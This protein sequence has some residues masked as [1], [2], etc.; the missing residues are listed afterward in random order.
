VASEAEPHASPEAGNPFAAAVAATPRGRR[1]RLPEY[2]RRSAQYRAQAEDLGRLSHKI[3]NFRG[4]S[5]AV[6]FIALLVTAFGESRLVPALIAV[7]GGAAFAVLVVWHARVFAAQDLAWRWWRV[8]QSAEARCR[9]TWR[10]LKDDGAEFIKP[11]HPYTADLDVFGQGS[12]FQL[13][14]V[15]HT[16]HGRRALAG[17]LS[18]AAPD[19]ELRQRQDAVRVLGPELELRQELE[20][21]SLGTAD[22]PHERPSKGSSARDLEA[23]LAWAESEPRLSKDPLLVWGSRIFPPITL[24]SMVATGVFDLSSFVWGVPLIVQ[25]FL[26]AR[27]ASEAGRVF[28]IVSATQGAFTRFK[29]TFK[30]L[31]DTSFDSPLLATLRNMLRGSSEPA[32]A[33]M[34]RF[35]RALSWFELRHNGM[36]YPFVTL[37]LLW[38]IHSVLALERW[39]AQTGRSL[40]AWFEA[41]GQ[42]E[43]L[44]SLAGLGYDNP[45][46]SLPEVVNSPVEFSA[47]DL[48]HPLLPPEAR[49][50]NNVYLPGPGHAL[51]VTGS[52]MS[53]KSTLL[54]AMGLAVV[55]ALAGAPVC[56]AR[57][58]VGRSNVYTSMRISDSL[59]GGVSHFYA[60][61]KKLRAAV[62]ATHEPLPLF[63]L[64][65]E[66]LHGT[67]SEER[68][69]GARWVLAE[70]LRAGAIGA[71]STHDLGLCQLPPALMQSVQ[72]VHFRESVLNGKM[73]F[74]YKLRLGPVTG[75][76]AL[77]LMRSL[78][79][80][81]PLPE[82]SA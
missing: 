17:F 33:Q 23:L 59:A 1:T 4:L 61:L 29:P 62:E 38:D 30:R 69:L 75:G 13:M 32:S 79:L 22:P 50:G 81:V 14:S 60:E 58:R 73:V 43:A 10:E 6:A 56:A 76:N 26:T 34:R 41:L 28:N 42:W 9:E 25:L 20:A 15:A 70:L 8:N 19:V 82:A 67:N 5:F 12:L 49:V 3:S 68:Q 57:L 78:G 35:E 46:F 74:D 39:Q 55:L 71:V 18:H 66:I 64:L 72:S 53:G 52:N 2:Q 11:E 40:R 24:L 80:D 51:L 27:A 54:R 21:L 77:R 37:L 45:E 65:D 47:D 63:F 36:I 44:S 48:G 31:E 16:P 7:L